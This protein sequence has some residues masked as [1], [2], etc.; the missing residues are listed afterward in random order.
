MQ[1]DRS[2]ESGFTLIEALIAMVILAVGLMATAQ[3]FVVATGSNQMANKGTATATQATEVMERLKAVPFQVLAATGPFPPAFPACA[4]ACDDN[5]PN[6]CITAAAIDACRDVAGLG[7]IVTR[8]QIQVAETAPNAAGNTVP[9]AYF[10]TVQSRIPGP[11]GGTMTQ[12]EFST[13]RACTSQ[14][15]PP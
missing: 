5:P 1:R 7:S 13:L 11:F 6:D 3:L 14:G 9:S 10:I 8:W 12:S 4:A 15:C 2:H